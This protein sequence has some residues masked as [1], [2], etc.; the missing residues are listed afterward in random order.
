M[1]NKAFKLKQSILRY[2]TKL[3]KKHESDTELTN[4]FSTLIFSVDNIGKSPTCAEFVSYFL[5]KH[6]IEVDQYQIYREGDLIRNETVLYY[7]IHEA[8]KLYCKLNKIQNR[9]FSE[10]NVASEF[11][12]IAEKKW[13]EKRQFLRKELK[14][15]DDTTLFDRLLSDFVNAICGK[16][17]KGH[18]RRIEL[19]K[20]FIAHW[21][22]QLMRK[23]FYGAKSIKKFGNESM[24]VLYSVDQKTGKSV[25]VSKLLSAFSEFGFMWKADFSRLEDAFSTKNLAMNYVVVFDEMARA[26][27]SNMAKFKH[28]VTEEETMFRGMYT[29]KEFR[30]PKLCSM[31]GTT[32]ASCRTLFNDTSGLRRFH[33]ITVNGI[34]EG[35]IDL[36]YLDNFDFKMLLK[37]VPFNLETS[38]LFNYVTEEE[39]RKYDEWMR[40]RHVVELW[41]D[42]FTLESKEEVLIP[43]SVLYNRFSLWASQN[44]YRHPYVPNTES[45]RKKMEE[46]GVEKGRTTRFGRTYRGYKVKIR[47]NI[48][49][50]AVLKE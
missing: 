43:I 10:R 16:K 22:W 20:G 45:F 31:I 7:E 36:N 40:P 37:T 39:L 34:K 32:N 21:L 23:L 38:P 48:D 1:K 5:D 17:H 46:L 33:E 42:D 35:G 25:T 19:I 41:L 9:S 18:K 4:Y 44:G 28:I 8:Y 15:I 13:R 2:L 14:Y 47:K 29:Q 50:E 3:S 30:M 26:S 24:L 12:L 27:Q 6:K 49:L 11:E